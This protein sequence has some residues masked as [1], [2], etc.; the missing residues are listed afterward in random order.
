[1]STT[2]TLFVMVASIL[3]FFMT[4]G[5]AF[6][7]GGMVSRRNSVNTLLSV[8][9]ISGL[10]IILWVTLGYSL[11]F[12]GNVFGLVGNLHA[13][14]MSNV[15]LDQLT[16]GKIPLGLY[17]LF[18]M[19]F[20]IITPALFVGAIVGRVRFKFLMVFIICW[21][22]CVYY[23]LVH[24]I[25][26][27]GLLSKLGA[28]DFAGGTVVHINA[29][30]TALVLSIM[31]GPRSH[32]EDEHANHSWI[33]LGTAILWL[34]WYGFNAGSALA[35]NDVAMQVMITT[36]IATAA[37]MVAWQLLE[38]WR[39]GHIT[40]VGTCSGALCGL[41][42]ITPAAGYVAIDS[43]LWIGLIGSVVSFLFV[44][45]IKP[46]IHLDD[47]LDAFGCHGVSGIWGSIATGLFA[48]HAINGHVTSDGL[49]VGGGWHL[50]SIQLLTTIIVIA[51]TLIIS[52]LLIK[53]ISY[54]M[55]IRVSSND[56]ILGL[57]LSQ[58]NEPLYSTRLA[59]ERT[60]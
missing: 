24:M 51:W 4:P 54:W 11:S 58:H 16:T 12:N 49:F 20:A 40:L 6:F 3:V 60:E 37:S 56:E 42:A 31:V 19:M 27:N 39:V 23:P 57:D 26:G 5:L 50:F 32:P 22:V 33:L 28:L 2:N 13:M 14:M 48:S 43:A 59:S 35:I 46:R 25:W 44:T 41:V 9:F 55:Q 10:A 7:Y 36:T 1:M 18:Q 15:R 30:I 53:F 38:V 52:M 21:S 17:S 34:G 29:G 45:L 47:T 8:F